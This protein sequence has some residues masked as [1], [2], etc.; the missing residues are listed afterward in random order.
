VRATDMTTTRL[1][2]SCWCSRWPAKGRVGRKGE[3]GE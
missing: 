2:A 3:S 1:L